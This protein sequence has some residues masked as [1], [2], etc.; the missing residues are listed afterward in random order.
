MTVRFKYPDH[1]IGQRSII[2]IDGV[3]IP[4]RSARGI[5]QSMDDV[6]KGTIDDTLAGGLIYYGIPSLRTKYVSV[7]NFSDNYP[8]AHMPR[9]QKTIIECSA[10]FILSGIVD[11]ADFH[12]KAVPDSIRYLDVMMR[13]IAEPGD[14]LTGLPIAWTY[15]NPIMWFMVEAMQHTRDEWGRTSNGTLQLRE[16]KPL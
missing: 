14:D 10:F 11:E 15:W 13:P 6:G 2:K 12:R 1:A 9:G 5:T 7:L 8:L 3:S 16:H 4:S